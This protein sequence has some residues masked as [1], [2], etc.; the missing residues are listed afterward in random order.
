MG[1]DRAK[2]QTER[3][4]PWA[5][6]KSWSFSVTYQAVTP[7]ALSGS[8]SGDNEADPRGPHR[9][10]NGQ[11]ILPGSSIIGAARALHEALTDSCLRVIDLDFLP[12]HRDPAVAQAAAQWRMAVAT[13]PDEVILCDPITFAGNPYPAVWIKAGS[14]DRHMRVNATQRFH[15]TAEDHDLTVRHARLEGGEGVAV[16]RCESSQC[17]ATHWRTIVSSTVGKRV[18][19]PRHDQHP[20]HLPFAPEGSEDSV[21]PLSKSVTSALAYDAKDAGDVVAA[22][23]VTTATFR[24]VTGDRRSARGAAARER[25]LG[26]SGWTTPGR[27]N[28]LVGVVANGRCPPG[29]RQRIGA[30]TPC[31][32]ATARCP[33]CAMFGM[34]EERDGGKEQGAATVQAYRGHVRIGMASVS[35]VDEEAVRLTEMGAPRPGAGQFY[36]ENANFAGRRAAKREGP[37]ATGV[38]LNRGS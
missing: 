13:G 37:S 38:G 28:L 35:E 2:E 16:T 23:R 3:A 33:S 36:L 24:S 8:G 18:R 17:D 5:P 25:R 14:L 15:V 4:P 10:L 1:L 29:V 12:V 32:D 27:A 20:Y 30:Y 11:A 22:R 7:L 9:L 6:T 26:T 31:D 21:A 34:V 19:S